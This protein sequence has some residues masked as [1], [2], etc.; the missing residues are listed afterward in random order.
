MKRTR[1]MNHLGLTIALAGL[2]VILMTTSLRAASAYFFTRATIGSI[3]RDSTSPSING[4]GS[5]IAFHS[6]AD[7]L[8]QGIPLGQREIWLYDTAA[9]A[10]TRIT[11]GSSGRES[12][13][14]SISSDGTKIAFYS[15][16]DLL[17]Q[18]I[19]QY[20][21]EI[22]LYDTATMT[23]MR[24]TTGSIGRYSYGAS[25][26]SDGTKIAFRSSVDFLDQGIPQSQYEI[27][28]YDTATMTFT[29]VTTGNSG[30][31][32]YGPS[33]SGDGS[34]IAFY[35]DAD[36]LGQGIPQGQMEIWLYDTATMTLTRVTTGSSD[37]ASRNPSINS[38]GTKIA[39][40][41]DT[42]FLGQGVLD[43]Q[44]EIWLYD[45]ATMTLIQVTTGSIGRESRYPSINSDGNRIAFY[46]DVNFLGQVGIPRSQNE[47]WLATS[48]ST[49]YL[50]MIVMNGSP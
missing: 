10:L 13:S 34:K 47:I 16:A 24:V 35:S 6:D 2:L 1:R 21:D 33:I 48:P 50:P 4:D 26:N 49:C 18:G 40:S 29:R 45:T 44:D 9:K 12:R 14:P 36:F 17:G 25:I 8:G 39:F 15:D 27:W 19:P 37:G 46:S 31:Y 28:L 23:L 3:D 22:W 11:T 32:S 43:D 20:Q 42:D 30:R 7:L 38:D 5:R 41:S